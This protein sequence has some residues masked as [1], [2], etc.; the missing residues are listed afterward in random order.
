VTGGNTHRLH[1]RPR[2]RARA[3]VARFIPDRD[4]DLSWLPGGGAHPG[5]RRGVAGR[6][7]GRDAAGR[8]AACVERSAK[9]W[10]GVSLPKA[11]ILPV[12]ASP[13]LDLNGVEVTVE[14]HFRLRRAA[15]RTNR[16]RTGAE[17]LRHHKNRA[18]SRAVAGWQSAFLP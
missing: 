5:P 12:G 4:A 11:E 9:V 7:F 1:E 10:P 2:M 18:L 6:G 17:M 15:P 3:V 13:P 14:L 8:N 16:L